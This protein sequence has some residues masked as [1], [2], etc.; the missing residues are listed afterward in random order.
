MG[1][2]HTAGARRVLVTM[3]GLV[4]AGAVACSD[5]RPLPT[6]P[7]GRPTSTSEGSHT[8]TLLPAPGATQSNGWSVNDSGIASGWSDASGGRAIRWSEAGVAEDIL[9]VDSGTRGINGAGGIVGW[10]RHPDGL[11]RAY[12]YTG[13]VR[14][15]LEKLEPGGRGSAHGINDAGTV[16]GISSME[17]GSNAVV[18]RQEADGSYGAP[19]ALGFGNPTEGPQVNDRGDIVFSAYVWNLHRPVIWPVQPDGSYGEPIWLGRPADG[20]YYARDMND[21]GVV[22][23]SRHQP[24]EGPP[25]AVVWLPGDYDAPI[26]LGIGEAWAI[27][28]HNQIVGTRGG[29]LPVFGGASRRPALWALEA[30]GTISGPLDIGTPS[31]YQS[32]GA[33][34]INDEGV[35]IG[36]SWGPEEVQATLWTPRP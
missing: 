23:G 35:I 16:V 28:E 15:D 29:H 34:D 12:V 31:G 7:D 14:I 33:R 11:Q 18:W 19:V 26:D 3:L 4:A 30:D 9:G 13:G 6:E 36:S 25:V 10:A 20:H 27:N 1:A 8:A 32:G 22:V 24:S 5:A 17:G 2:L 21:Q